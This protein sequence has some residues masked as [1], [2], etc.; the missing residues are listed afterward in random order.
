MNWYRCIGGNGGGGNKKAFIAADAHQYFKVPFYGDEDIVI[1]TDLIIPHIITQNLIGTLWSS[2]GITFYS[3]S[4]RLYFRNAG[5]APAFD[6]I[7][8]TSVAIEFK[9]N[10][11]TLIYNG[12]TYGGTG[13][14]SSHSQIQLF[15]MDN[16]RFAECAMSTIEI[17]KDG[18]LSAKLVPKEDGN[19]DGYYYDEINEIDYYSLTTTPFMYREF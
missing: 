2:S 12:T 14:Q 3:E 17:Y 5:G 1:K 13:T 9:T 15:G 16:Q 7:P 8:W 11:T 6:N 18:V 4:N 19:G 10:P